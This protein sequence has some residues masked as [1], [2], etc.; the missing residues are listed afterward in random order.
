M[1]AKKQW[2]NISIP[3]PVF[4]D[5]CEI[6]QNHLFLFC[7][8]YPKKKIRPLFTGII[9]NEMEGVVISVPS[10]TACFEFREKW[11]QT[12]F[13]WM[14]YNTCIDNFVVIFSGQSP[15]EMGKHCHETIR[16]SLYY[17]WIKS[18]SQ[19]RI[20]LCSVIWSLKYKNN[21]DKNQYQEKKNVVEKKKKFLNQ[22]WTNNK[23]SNRCAVAANWSNVAVMEL[24]PFEL[25]CKI[26]KYLLNNINYF[27]FNFE[28]NCYL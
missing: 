11:F 16:L 5:F 23:Q 15:N 22:L 8:N 9:P 17:L 12:D 24:K 1:F 28:I 10:T 13:C 7:W 18:L 6:G 4:Y 21:V 14:S 26:F 20:S 27:S 19:R 3:V 2:I 25:I